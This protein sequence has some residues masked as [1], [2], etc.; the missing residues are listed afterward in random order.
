MGCGLD[1]GE[2]PGVH[3]YVEEAHLTPHPGNSCYPSASV[4]A[5]SAGM[6]RSGDENSKSL[7]V[8]SKGKNT[9]HAILCCQK[10][11]N[12]AQPFVVTTK[13]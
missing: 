12:L 13:T 8:S 11:G 5:S 4:T 9:T 6:R 3:P 2:V 10:N 7:T 1:L